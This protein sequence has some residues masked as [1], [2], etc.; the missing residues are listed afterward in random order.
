MADFQA[1]KVYVGSSQKAIARRFLGSKQ[2]PESHQQHKPKTQEQQKE[3]Q[4]I[5]QPPAFPPPSYPSGFWLTQYSK[6]S[7]FGTN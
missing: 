6:G 5:L 4:Q 2:Q 1:F 7:R 3:Q